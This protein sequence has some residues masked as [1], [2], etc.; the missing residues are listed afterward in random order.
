MSLTFRAFLTNGCTM[1]DL[2]AA[3]KEYKEVLK[4]EYQKARAIAADGQLTIGQFLDALYRTIRSTLQGRRWAL[5]F[6]QD[7]FG[8]GQSSLSSFALRQLE[9]D[10]PPSAPKALPSMTSD[11]PNA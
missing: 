2:E 10:R 8:H 5:A 11:S 1:S 4:A 9:Y 3:Y 6:D 7:G